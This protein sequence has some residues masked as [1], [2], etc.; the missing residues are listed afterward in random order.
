MKNFVRFAV[1]GALMA[2][3]ATAQAQTLPS[4]G[5]ADLWLFVSDA[6]AQETFA[7]DTGISLSS[8]LPTASLVSGSTLS[9]AISANVNLGAS[10]AL[11]NFI[12]SANAAGQTLDWAVLG[13][14]Y[15]G[16][17]GNGKDTPGT[18]STLAS[19]PVAQGAN[20]SQ[21]T[22]AN[23]TTIASGL[24]GDLGYL[25][26]NG[27]TAGGSVFTWAN[28]SIGTNVWGASTGGN[29]GS[30]NLYGQGP[31]QSG[32]ALGSATG[33]YGLTGNGGTG[34]L[35]SY[36]LSSE[37]T[38]SANGTLSTVPLPAAVW[39]FG[40]GLLGLVGVGRRRAATQA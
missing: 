18:V 29:G 27:Y 38:L 20:I 35:Q 13:A 11:T 3:Y 21:L 7:E 17:L 34:Q 26:T 19:D 23:L 22:Y 40:S 2:G 32:I 5:S 33:L 24:N 1:A 25:T 14:Q 37:L 6:S 36:V 39:L 9:T 10:T 15:P 30:T 16:G 31:D 4:S 28:G 12:N 8:L